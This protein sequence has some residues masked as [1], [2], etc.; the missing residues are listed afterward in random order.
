MKIREIRFSAAAWEKLL[1]ADHSLVTPIAAY[2]RPVARLHRWKPI[3]SVPKNCLSTSAAAAP[4][5]A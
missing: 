4:S 3:R 1:Y 2:Y 5:I